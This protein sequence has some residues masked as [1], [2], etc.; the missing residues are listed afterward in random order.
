MSLTSDKST[1]GAEQG[2][3]DDQAS[4][5]VLVIGGGLAAL[6]AAISAADTGAS[7]M[8]VNKGITG[9]SGSSAK[10]AGILA[11]PFG[12]GDLLVRPVPDSP[13]KHA[14]DT[15]KVGYDIGDP[16]LVRYVADNAM[17]AVDWLESLGIRF[18]RADDGG[19]V[20]LNAPGNSCPRAVSAIGG[21]QAIIAKL[22]N[23]AKIRGVKII[24]HTIVRQILTNN[25]A[26]CGVHLSGE[27]SHRLGHVIIN[28]P[29]VILAA[30]GATGMF[31]TV[32]GD[33][34]NVGSS[35]M[36]G[37]DAGA[38]L[39]NLEFIEF[40]LIYRVNGQILR[41]AGMAP[42]LSR[43]GRLY[44]RN[45]VDLLADCF[46]K[47]P[48]EQI[49]RAE[50]LRMVEREITDGRGP[51]MLDCKHFSTAIWAEFKSSQGSI[52]L[53]KIAAAGCNYKSEQIEVIPAA[54]SVLAGLLIDCAARTS[55]QGLFAAGEN[56]TG[57]HGAGRLSGNGLTACVV[58]GRSAGTNA[59][60]QA[61]LQRCAAPTSGI[62]PTLPET[63]LPSDGD[64]DHLYA[65]PAGLDIVVDKIKAT[66]GQKLGII[67]NDID[68][69]VAKQQ[70]SAFETKLGT[71]DIDNIHVFEARQMVRLAGLMSKAAM[72]RR[73]SRGV[74]FRSDHQKLNTNWTKSQTLAKGGA[75]E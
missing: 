13:L 56:A 1:I 15:L 32:S 65:M 64:R 10:A 54:H 30:G 33:S 57:I 3:P 70:F 66:V 74:Q 21:G 25:A 38:R 63:V 48:A 51:V 60:R 68:L 31:P 19:Y 41:I 45:G 29:A 55:V 47:T 9:Q 71:F 46:P 17:G 43:G 7:V 39:G 49:G 11:A 59:G 8:L 23:Q 26:V 35:L 40:T 34:G 22:I 67:R 61:M 12:H 5:D 53:D 6:A 52:V 58:M 24:D 2:T 37:Y 69:Q 27:N 73:E 50:I 44:N 42:F 75:V 72:L 16:K 62:S 36:L 18:S 4:C 20:Q 28:T 14:E